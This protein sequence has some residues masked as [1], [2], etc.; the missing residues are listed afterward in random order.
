MDTPANER[1]CRN[2]R[3][4][5]EAEVADAMATTEEDAE[6]VGT[7]P[8]GWEDEDDETPGRGLRGTTRVAGVSPQ[9]AVAQQEAEADGK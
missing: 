9:W 4:G 7:M 2:E 6:G 3:H 5:E 8:A 1:R